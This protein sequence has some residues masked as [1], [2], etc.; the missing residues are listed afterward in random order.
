MWRRLIDSPWPYFTAAGLLLLVAIATQFEI[1]FPSRPEGGVEEIERLRDRSDLSV[2]FILV[3][4]MRADRLGVYGYGR[5]TTPNL[6]ALAERGIVFTN[7]LAQSSWTKTSMASLWTATY[8]MNNGIVRYSDV[9]PAEAV[10]P[11]ERFREAGYRTAGIWRNGWVA[12]NFG[13]DQGFEFYVNPRPGRERARLQRGNPSSGAVQGND[14]DVT[15]SAFEF[16]ESYGR[17]RFLLYL[18][19]MDLHQYVYDDKAEHFGTSYSDVYDQSVNWADR[20]IGA[21]VAKLDEVGVLQKTLVVVASDHGE[22]FLEHGFEGHARNL[23][24]EVTRVPLVIA[25]PFRLPQGIRVDA[26]ASNVDVWPT[27]LDLVGLP[28]L[29]GVDGRSLVPAI[30]AAARGER[31]GAPARP[32]FAHLDRRWGKAREESDPLVS[33]TEGSLR[34][35]LPVKEPG[36]VELYDLAADPGE[37]NNLAGERAAERDR[38]AAAAKSH[39]EGAAIPWGRAPGEVE[40]DELRLNQLRALGYVVRP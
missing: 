25:L 3:D 4:T 23:Y 29:P 13:F 5:P 6:D 20:L 18:H 39:F 1:R 19:F 8:P 2:L 38:L 26:P 28:P 16:I 31:D 32:I 10:L 12:P 21:I 15:T 33:V 11:A 14:E 35:L 17:S 7:V 37:R 22:A 36:S 24:G 30:L 34:L 40:L 27:L 9:L